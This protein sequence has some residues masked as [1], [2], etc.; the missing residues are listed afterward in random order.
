MQKLQE[1][2]DNRQSQ[3]AQLTAVINSSETTAAAAVVPSVMKMTPAS[4]D[5]QDAQRSLP[6]PGFLPNFNDT[7]IEL[8]IRKFLEV[9]DQEDFSI[10][11]DEAFLNILKTVDEK[12]K[13]RLV[14]DEYKLAEIKAKIKDKEREWQDQTSASSDDIYELRTVAWSSWPWKNKMGKSSYHYD[15]F[16][17]YRVASESALARELQLELELRGKKAFL[18]QEELK[19][20]EDWRQGFVT[21]LKRSRVVILLVSKGCIERMRNSS[22][23]V[24]NVLLEWETALCAQEMGFCHVLP[25]FI[26]VG[27]IDFQT[28]PKERATITSKESSSDMMCQQSAFT[29]LSQV[30]GISRRLYHPFPKEG[31]HEELI[32][33]LV[34][35]LDV[36]GGVYN[37]K[38]ARR[39]ML[40]YY[41]LASIDTFTSKH[42]DPIK[43][44]INDSLQIIH[45]PRK[46][47]DKVRAALEQ[48]KRGS[49]FRSRY[50]VFRKS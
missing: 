28:F 30:K 3:I 35:E 32:T 20:G 31:C 17:S 21:G 15:Y 40:A 12:L 45:V 13:R 9:T 42:K 46:L 41:E 49:I 2:L 18:D 38:V 23:E 25:V 39:A 16:I 33:A 19:D 24:D 6:N 7:A 10:T 1:T 48:N 50:G 37:D 11:S 34:K 47:L 43:T 44:W 4:P 27:E 14:A 36:F 22:Q 5:A 26:G 29:T 8:T